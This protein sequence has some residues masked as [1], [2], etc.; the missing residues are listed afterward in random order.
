[1]TRIFVYDRITIHFH[2]KIILILNELFLIFLG[3]T[4]ISHDYED[5]TDVGH[6]KKPGCYS[7]TINYNASMKQIVALIQESTHCRQLLQV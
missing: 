2:K 3:S 6:C 5:G 4:L 1:M 7:Q